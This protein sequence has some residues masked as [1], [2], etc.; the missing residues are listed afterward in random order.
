MRA[1]VATLLDRLGRKKLKYREFSDSFADMELW[2]IFERLLHDRGFVGASSEAATTAPAQPLQA[3]PAA[4]GPLDIS[5]V[6]PQRRP[7][8]PGKGIFARY[9]H[10]AA[11]RPAGDVRDF[12]RILSERTAA[13]DL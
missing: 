10:G 13:G 4:A 2:P 11:A 7:T 9:D 5:P 3:A 12:L 8:S 6:I 1:D